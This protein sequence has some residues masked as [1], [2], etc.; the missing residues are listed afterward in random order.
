MEDNKT[1]KIDPELLERVN[2]LIRRK[3]KKFKYANAKQFVN[4][5][6]V[7]LLEEEEK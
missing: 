2:R 5:A 1:V 6:V 3:L 4:S 7:R